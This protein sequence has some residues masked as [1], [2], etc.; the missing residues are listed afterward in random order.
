MKIQ[1]SPAA[2]ADLESIRAYIANDSPR[3]ANR[4]ST[5]IKEAILRLRDFPFSGREG[6]VPE[7]RELV[8][9]GT[10]YIAAYIIK[11]DEILIATV[12]HGQQDWPKSFEMHAGNNS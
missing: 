1:W 9:P 11:D 7:T 8:V 2:I 6:R 5:R 3:A 12:L 10:V 4:I